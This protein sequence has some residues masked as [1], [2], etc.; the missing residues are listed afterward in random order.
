MLY[1]LNQLRDLSSLFTRK[2][3]KRWLKDD[4]KS[5]DIKLERYNLHKKNKGSNYL[6]FLKETYKI[7]E[8]NYPNE[9]ILKN[10]FLNKWLKSELGN[11]NSLIINE[12]RT[13]KAIAD[14][15]MFNGVS[16]AFEIKT[17]LDKEY[18]L[19]NQISEY[20][21]IFNELY[22]IIPKIQINKYI[23]YDDCIGIIT[24][25]S[26]VKN[27]E[28]IKK[29]VKNEEIDS[30]TLIEIL[31]TK[32]YLEIVYKYYGHLPEM[33]VFTQ[34][35]V[36][37]NLLSKIPNQELNSLFLQIIKKRKVNNLFFNKVNNEFNQICLSLN[38]KDSEKNELIK[39]L[40]TNIN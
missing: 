25:D 17:I 20:K 32:E 30:N 9:Y 37:K 38:L 14:L 27:F 19:S 5:I 2:E 8:E 35:E 16:K 11:Q 33:S 7:L 40:K 3:V 1:Q 26:E 18:R 10:E 23:N 12:F 34:Y 29:A 13:G 24:Y 4:F 21:K 15:A 39:K 28:L 31:H 22:I 6:K 36:C